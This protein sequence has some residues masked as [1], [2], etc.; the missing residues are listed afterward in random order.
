MKLFYFFNI[1]PSQLLYID[2][3]KQPTKKEIKGRNLKKENKSNVT[4]LKVFRTELL[5]YR[6][7][8]EDRKTSGV[9]SG[10]F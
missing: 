6:Q 5:T 10:T 3:N 8:K 2:E 7:V 4:I 9:T 1:S